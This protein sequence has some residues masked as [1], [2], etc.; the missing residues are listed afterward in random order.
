MPLIVPKDK[1]RE[2][3]SVNYRDVLSSEPVSVK[4]SV[5]NEQM[6]FL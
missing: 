3:F 1:V 6:T 4:V 5:E 2:W